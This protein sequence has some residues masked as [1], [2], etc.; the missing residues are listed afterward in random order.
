MPMHAQSACPG[1]KT[2]PSHAR[3]RELILAA[4]SSE[5]V[6]GALEELGE[7][8]CTPLLQALLFDDTPDAR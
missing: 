2:H 1:S 3:R 8:R 7:L 4:E 6:V 5:Q